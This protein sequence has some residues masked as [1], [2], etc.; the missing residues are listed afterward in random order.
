[1][2]ILSGIGSA[3][4]YFWPTHSADAIPQAA[5][6]FG[7]VAFAFVL[8]GLSI[9]IWRIYKGEIAAI[10][11]LAMMGTLPLYLFFR[12]GEADHHG[13][14][15]ICSLANVLFLVIGGVG[16]SK[17]PMKLAGKKAKPS[18]QPMAPPEVNGKSPRG[19]F[20]TSGVAG[21]AGIWISAASQIPVLVGCGLAAVLIAFLAR[22]SKE[23]V[24][25][26][27]LWRV[28]GISGGLACIGFYLLEYFPSHLGLRMEVNNPV[29]AIA[30]VG[31][32]YFLECLTRYLSGQGPLAKN[33]KD[34]GR[35]TLS[36][37]A[38][39]APAVVI[40]MAK[41]QLFWVSDRFV[42]D[43][44][45]FYI[46]EFQGLS[47]YLKGDGAVSF[48]LNFLLAPLLCLAVSI[49][50]LWKG[51]ISQQR[52]GELLFSLGPALVVQILSISQVRWTGNA[53]AL[54]V[55][56]IIIISL[57]VRE[58]AT[59][60]RGWKVAALALLLIAAG[61]HPT[62]S[63]FA[64]ISTAHNEGT[65]ERE[66][67]PA[68]LTHDISLRIN[69]SYPNSHPRILSGP[70]SSTEFAYYGGDEVL[71]T[72]YWENRPGLEAAADIYAATSEAE[73]KGL[74]L[75]RGITHLVMFSWDSFAQS[76]VRLHRGLGRTTEA[77]DGCLASYLEGT[78]PQPIWLRPLYYPVPAAYQM[79]DAW[80]RIYQVVPD[81]TP[82]QWHLHVGMYQLDA[83]R[84]DLA[85]KSFRES[86]KL[87]PTSAETR[88]TMATV[89]IEDRKA[90]EAIATMMP[91]ISGEV[92]PQRPDLVESLAAEMARTGKQ[93]AA[94]LLY[95]ELVPYFEAKNDT[96]S[97]SRCRAAAAKN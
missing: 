47:E 72:L 64:A 62:Q 40:L 15:A 19:W 93:Y 21:A 56:T 22:Q 34:R 84:M 18:S 86:L 41:D 9:V 23:V 13:L 31:A 81:Q 97:A 79:K 66:F 27:E 91:L 20:I 42:F 61:A 44:H 49:G 38:V 35:L 75:K 78:R 87:D 24:A 16:L 37:L 10:F 54:W 6:Y 32:G 60:R 83:G 2:W 7:P 8:I 1:M 3:I 89:L 43:L 88:V 85:E 95:S 5:L 92:I 25:N 29:Y 73:F 14:V 50:L 26:P 33:W 57:I 12:A 36:L 53:S 67:L 55:V 69:R 82:A 46:R 45:R 68:I 70:T 4:S 17:A 11:C 96:I 80:V 76:Y 51:Q 65:V 77:R 63:I 28:W 71:G 52:R 30:W 59:L 74:L 48:G 90:D 94:K 58:S 39:A